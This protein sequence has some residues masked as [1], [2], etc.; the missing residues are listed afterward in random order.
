M[1]VVNAGEQILDSVWFSEDPE[2]ESLSESVFVWMA[3]EDRD[4]LRAYT[5][6]LMP[7]NILQILDATLQAFDILHWMPLPTDPDYESR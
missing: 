2:R 7:P 6:D 1:F 3:D 4:M 5:P